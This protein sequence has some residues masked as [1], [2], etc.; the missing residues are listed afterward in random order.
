MEKILT[1]IILLAFI[2]KVS[3][4]IEVHSSN[5]VGIGTNNPQYKLHVVGDTYIN[6]N[7]LLG[8]ASTFF[9]TTDGNNPVIFKSNNV[10]S[11]FTGSYGY[12][13]VS[14]GYATLSNTNYYSSQNTAVGY[15]ALNNCGTGS[16]NTAIG[17]GVLGS[18]TTGSM[19]TAIGLNALYSNIQGNRNTAI[20]YYTLFSN[21]TG[22]YNLANGYNA[23]YSNTTGGNNI[24]IGNSA[25]YFN[26]TGTRNTAVGI[27]ALYRNISGI[28]NIAI[29][30]ST[31]WFNTTGDNNTAIGKNALFHNSTGIYNTGLGGMALYRNTTNN[32]NTAVGYGA[33]NQFQSMTGD[34]NTAIGF[35]ALHSS[36]PIGSFNMAIGPNTF[37]QNIYGVTNFSTAIG[38]S[39]II[40][41]SNQVRIGDA[42]T[43]S[44]GG[45]VGWSTI[46]DRRAKKN[47][48]ADVPGLAFINS[49]QPV[50]YNMDLDAI[51]ELLKIEDLTASDEDNDI[52][53]KS[54]E[55]IELEKKTREAKEKQ[56]QTGF[57]AQEVEK[58]AKDAGYEFSGVD[59][60]ETGIYS[61]RYA[62]FVAPLVKAIQELS[63][64]NNRLQEQVNE[65]KKK[66]ENLE[67]K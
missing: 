60:D 24:A 18:N 7:L 2:V 51:D 47:I 42:S 8:G 61:L 46:S 33:L 50:T 54:D 25:L 15:S 64:Q 52:P 5:Q 6:G 63:E 20:G 39:A 40:T 43:A 21:T 17:A 53:P 11:G 27:E 44:I 48:R 55:L 35:N 19:N 66:I 59:V 26:S 49:L 3:G 31:L 30:D 41:G 12:S 38:Y 23:L 28:E 10:I 45:Y 29:G 9:G 37:F 62:E 16:Q 22:Q 4:Q 13:N 57:V 36:T 65:L 32:Y 1:I 34:Y 56:V 58:A 67:R 14:F